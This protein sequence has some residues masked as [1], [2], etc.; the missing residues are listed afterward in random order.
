MAQLGG[1]FAALVAP[2]VFRGFYELPLALGA[3]A[4]VVLI[5]LL[6]NAR[7][8][9][10]AAAAQRPF[11]LGRPA[12]LMAEGLTVLLLALLFYVVRLQNQQAL[13]MVRNFYGVLRVNIVP[14]G[15]SGRP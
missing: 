10:G 12:V 3:C 14:A 2:Y 13:V 8:R 9:R 5:A 6:N 1:L 11:R 4:I 7:G 15:A